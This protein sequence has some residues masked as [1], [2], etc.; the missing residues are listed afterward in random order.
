MKPASIA[1]KTVLLS[2][3]DRSI[4]SITISSEVTYLYENAFIGCTNLTEINVPWSE[5]QVE[6]APWGA[7]KATINYNYVGG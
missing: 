6:G 1:D 3:I 4:T 7:R 5:G 2:L